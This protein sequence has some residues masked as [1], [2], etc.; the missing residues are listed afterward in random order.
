MYQNFYEIDKLLNVLRANLESVDFMPQ[1]G[2]HESNIK[3]VFCWALEKAAM[4][5]FRTEV[6]LPVYP[7]AP[8]LRGL[9]GKVKSIIDLVVEINNYLIGFEFKT[10]SLSRVSHDDMIAYLN[11]LSCV[12][13]TCLGSLG[14][15]APF[16]FEETSRPE[17]FWLYEFERFPR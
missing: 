13:F 5:S 3:Y 17:S 7:Q 4:K 14:T 16:S 11:N 12:F 10:G 15:F 9:E 1:F 8:H 2:L 6:S